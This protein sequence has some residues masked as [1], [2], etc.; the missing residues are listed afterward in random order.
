MISTH[1][2]RLVPDSATT[3]PLQPHLRERLDE[4]CAPC[5]IRTLRRCCV[6]L[7]AEVLR[8]GT[9]KLS[10]YERLMGRVLSIVG[11][12]LS[13]QPTHLDVCEIYSVAQLREVVSSLGSLQF[14]SSLYISSPS[15]PIPSFSS[16]FLGHSLDHHSLS[17]TQFTRTRQK[18]IYHLLALFFSQFLGTFSTSVAL[19]RVSD[20][21]ICSSVTRWSSTWGM[22]GK[23]SFILQ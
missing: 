16:V 23:S 1:F 2:C 5:R 15:R 19:Q 10:L 11:S 18:G 6:R 17:P 13:F 3:F 14:Q 7:Q 9:T 21:S 12:S 22:N 4:D 8:H 20:S